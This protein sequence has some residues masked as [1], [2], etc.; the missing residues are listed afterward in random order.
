MPSLAARN[1][2]ASLGFGV[3]L[4]AL[5]ACTADIGGGSNGATAAGAAGI[6]GSAGQGPGPVTDPTAT[7]CD[8]NLDLAPPRVWRLNDQQYVTVVHDVF[9]AGITVPPDASSARVA[10]AE[11]AS[12]ALG[13]GISDVTT[14]QSYFRAAQSTAA[15]AVANVGA[16]LPCAT[17]DAA[18][19]ETFIRSKVSR[20]FRRP[21]SEQQLTDML[22][23]YQLGAEGGPNAG[24][25]ALL[26]YVLQAPGF[27]WRT[28]LPS[29]DATSS[30]QP[31]DAFD[32][33]SALSF[34]F[35]D[36]VPDDELWQK[37]V[38]GS[39][40]AP[41]VLTAQVDR[42][43]ALPAVKANIANKVGSWLSVHQIEVT[44]KDPQV[45]PEFTP[46]IQASLSQSLQLFLKDVVERGTLFDLVGSNRIYLNQDL[47]ALYGIG[48]VTGSALVPVDT[49]A[50]QWSGGILTQPGILAAKAKHVSR[51]DVVHRGLFIYD[52][53]VCGAALPPP[54]AVAQT[55]DASLPAT[56]TERDRANY[57][58]GNPQCNACHARFDP[59]GLLSERYDS[60]GR[61]L[62][63]DAT[64]QPIDQ[65]STITLGGALDG[66]ANG[67]P[68]LIARLKS[69][70]SFAVCAAS[71]VTGV[72]LGRVTTTDNSCSL[73]AVQDAFAADGSFSTL[74]K[75]IATSPAF[76]RRDG[77]LK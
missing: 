25:E 26:Q 76:A 36:S 74:F 44:A 58:E 50:P 32:L 4:L 48:G 73:K 19:V 35:I 7:P 77:R 16:L 15:S 8:P 20:A 31:L 40:T 71:K 30:A 65:T 17:P 54:P 70:R 37:A 51:G 12:S 1:L 33:A 6:A 43:I 62:E 21:V 24:V 64:G 10:G 34:L 57:R 59:L 2:K 72:A 46:A 75:A 49:S 22:A 68:D 55:L 53:M 47:A 67:L 60:I 56:A 42:L 52:T 63:T 66:P 41:T 14:A 61:Y 3:A 5:S 23:I 39:L 18:C 69:S 9:G 27:L 13:F 28:E 29:A 38:D 11:D 45:F